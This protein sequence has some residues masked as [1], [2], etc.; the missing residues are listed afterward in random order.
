MGQ[1]ALT[2]SLGMTMKPLLFS[3]TG[4]VHSHIA[5]SRFPPEG[6]PR[7][8]GPGN[9]PPNVPDEV[10]RLSVA[11]G[12]S[13]SLPSSP[14]LP[15]QTYMMPLRTSKRSPG[16]VC[17]FINLKVLLS[18]YCLSVYCLSVCQGKS[19]NNTYILFE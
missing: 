4:D 12:A 13:M 16:T 7:L 3:S 10:F 18:I 5:Q 8:Q 19:S 14:L 6:N 9:S 11:K 15:R 2:P 17:A 1:K